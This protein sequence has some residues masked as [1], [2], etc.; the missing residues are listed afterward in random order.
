MVRTDSTVPA[1]TDITLGEA[2]GSPTCGTCR[3]LVEVVDGQLV[4]VKRDR[5]AFDHA[6][7]PGVGGGL[8]EPSEAAVPA[9]ECVAAGKARYGMVLRVRRGD[10]QEIVEVAHVEPVAASPGDVL[11]VY[12]GGRFG[13]YDDDT[14][15]EVVP[16]AEWKA[17]KERIQAENQRAAMRAGVETLR[18]LLTDLPMPRGY[19]QV[20][21]Y[22]SSAEAVREWAERVGVEVREYDYEYGDKT[23]RRVGLEANLGEGLLLSLSHSAPV[24][25]EPSG[26]G[27]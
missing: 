1:P 19:L 3:G 12:A 4:H 27:S 15:L 7:T 9:R 5:I 11:I 21:G 13:T 6:A 10:A 17:H 16:K 23:H 8:V 22:L 18:T 26:S 14:E 25:D 24:V 2:A 20:Q